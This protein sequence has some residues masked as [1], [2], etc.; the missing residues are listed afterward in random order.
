MIGRWHGGD[1]LVDQEAAAI[2]DGRGLS[3][4]TVRAKLAGHA[5]A[6]DVATRA[7]LYDHEKATQILTAVQPRPA[8]SSAAQRARRG[9]A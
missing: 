8:R 1:F 2:S 3:K 4:H 6:C 9:H 5:T 7:P